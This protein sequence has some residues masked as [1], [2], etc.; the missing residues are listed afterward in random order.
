MPEQSAVAEKA[1]SPAEAVAIR[2]ALK[3]AGGKRWQLPYLEPYWN[4]HKGSR[5]V[6]SFC[7]GLAVALGLQPKKALLNDINPHLV[8]FYR[9][10]KK[11]LKTRLVFENDEVAYYENPSSIST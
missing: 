6:E 2:P 1:P 11:G 10:L 9:W 3:W 7:G 5:L 8:N 4:A